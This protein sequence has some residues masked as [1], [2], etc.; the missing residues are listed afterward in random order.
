MSRITI[1]MDR[2]V[3]CHKNVLCFQ[4]IPGQIRTDDIPEV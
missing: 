1:L 2:A 3:I 4:G